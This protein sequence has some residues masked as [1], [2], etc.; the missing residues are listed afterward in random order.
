[1]KLFYDNSSEILRCSKRHDVFVAFRA[2]VV[3]TAVITYAV[4]PVVVAYDVVFDECTT[5]T[6]VMAGCI[7]GIFVMAMIGY[8]IVLICHGDEK[9]DFRHYTI[10][11]DTICMLLKKDEDTMAFFQNGQKFWVDKKVYWVAFYDIN[12][13][14]PIIVSYDYCP[15]NNRKK[16]QK[17]VS[18]FAGTK[19][20]LRCA[21][22]FKLEFVISPKTLTDKGRETLYKHTHN[23]REMSAEVKDWL[24]SVIGN[25][26]D[27]NILISQNT[28]DNNPYGFQQMRLVY[29]SASRE[30]DYKLLT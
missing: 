13:S 1:M 29:E 11:A 22:R 26:D 2:A 24:L 10:D 30:A 6:K 7:L 9:T 3:V 4:L 27:G 25:D 15:K 12:E 18:E 19:I 14:F 21:V 23:E 5:T 17:K 20:G 28:L 8:V 16:W